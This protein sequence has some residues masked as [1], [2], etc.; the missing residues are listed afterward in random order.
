M[1][2]ISIVMA[3]MDNGNRFRRRN[4]LAV[5]GRCAELFPD[6]E[7]IVAEQGESDIAESFSEISEHI[8]HIKVD[9]GQRFHKT[10]LLNEAI[11]DASGEVIMMVDADAYV[12][13]ALAKSIKDGEKLLLDGCAGIVYPFDSVD[14]LTDGQTRRLLAGEKINSA[15]CE[16]GAAIHRQT[17]LCNMYR[18]SAWSSVR[19]FDEEFYEWG[20]EDD[21]FAYKIRR[22]VGPI[23]RLAGHIYHLFHQQV[24]TEEY[25]KSSVYKF[26]RKLCACIRR[27]SDDDFWDYEHG[28]VSLASLAEKY[29]RSGRLDIRLNWQ[30]TPKT[31]LS[32]DTTIYD[33]DRTGEMSITKLL[34]AVLAEDGLDYLKVFVDEIFGSVTDLSDEQRAEI[35]SFIEHA[36]RTV[37]N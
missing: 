27:M 23:S 11:R 21:A 10:K 5:L 6:T 16:H 37:D 19:G 1:S 3:Y 25:Q 36:K 14:Y 29:D 22:L 24:N 15:F 17:G 2:N 30:C 31:V 13:E 33:I 20:A 8:K 35:D 12:D 28:N 26:N 34:S 9:D 18:K 32:I 4:I 7:I